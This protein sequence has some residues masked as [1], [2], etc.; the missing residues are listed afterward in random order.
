MVVEQVKGVKVAGQDISVSSTSGSKPV[1]KD[2]II[3]L[4]HGDPTMFESFWRTMG[5]QGTVVIPGWQ[6]MSY[7]SDVTNVC[8]FLEPDF[9]LQ[10]RRLHNLVGNA[11]ADDRHIIVGTGSTQ[12][13]QA[14]LYALSPSDA[15]EP[16]SV[17]S[18]VPYYS[19]YSAVTDYLRSGLFKWAG[20]ASAF[21][22]DSYIEIICSPNNPDGYIK[23]PVL[24]SKKGKMVHDLAYYWPQYTAITGPADNDIM[25]FTVSKSTGHAGTRLGWAL[26]KDREV[27]KRMTKFI[28]LNTIGVSKDSQ[29][30]AA[31]ILKV[32]S[33]GYELPV[34]D[35]AAR[36]FDY[37]RRI[38]G[39]RWERLREV[40]KTTGMFSLPEYESDHCNFIGQQTSA[41][42]AFAWLKCERDGIEDC[43]NYLKSYKILTR[44]GKHFGVEA[45]YVR[46][47]MLDRD[48]TFDLFIER[49][50]SLK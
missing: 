7:F 13:F 11:V 19:S 32:V 28:E 34:T 23:H 40:A 46:V 29:V 8:W 21:T 42:P 33:D 50:S 22:G 1:S 30:R 9:A 37:G 26:V 3:N 20:D 14:A 2:S 36:L 17:V 35:P 16:M 48:E 43:E 47:S 31:Q 45:K 4:D 15:T 27:A 38:L 41:N 24:N 6:T 18:A 39:Y 49:L 25:L 10:I 5:G 44:S 12:L